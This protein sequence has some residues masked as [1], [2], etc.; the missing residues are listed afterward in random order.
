MSV[1]KFGR[2]GK[3]HPV[4]LR[5]EGAFGGGAG[6]QRAWI[7]WL[8]ERSRR[9]PRRVGVGSLT[10]VL[11]GQKT[12]VFR[13]QSRPE[14]EE[15]SLSV[16]YLDPEARSR[17]L[18]IVCQDASQLELCL[19][20][21][22]HLC[23]RGAGSGAGAAGSSTGSLLPPLLAV[24]EAD[25]SLLAAEEALNEDLAA[26]SGGSS[27]GGAAGGGGGGARSEGGGSSESS[28]RRPGRGRGEVAGAGAPAP[29][30]RSGGGSGLND[31]FVWGGTSGRW[32][33]G[34]GSSG[35]G[36]GAAALEPRLLRGSEALNVRSAGV[37]GEHG[38]LVTR[39]GRT[40]SW[41][42]GRGGRLGNGS[43]APTSGAGPA[44]VEVL[45]DRRAEQ[46]SCG[47]HHSV[48]LTQE[49]EVFTWGDD[50]AACG[51][52]GHGIPG[53][54][55]LS[56]RAVGAQSARATEGGRGGEEGLRPAEGDGPAANISWLPK[57]V[58]RWPA[59]AGPVCFVACGSWHTAAV[60]EAGS[61][62]TWGCGFRGRLGHGG[63]GRDEGR[64]RL[65]SV[66]SGKRVTHVA[67]GEWHTA[68]VVDTE[69]YSAGEGEQAVV[70]P[71]FTW[72]WGTR[73]SLGYAPDGSGESSG[74][75]MSP[76]AVPGIFFDTSQL[77]QVSCGEGHTAA[78]DVDGGAYVSGRLGGAWESEVFARVGGPLRWERVSQIASGNHHLAAL[79]A[80]GRC[81]TWG[82]GKDGQL[83]H[84]EAADR[85]EPQE[86]A[87]LAGRVVLQVS[88]GETSTAAVCEY[89]SLEAQTEFRE[90][91]EATKEMFAAASTAAMRRKA[92][93]AA[94]AAGGGSGG[95][96]GDASDGE[97]V[98]LTELKIR[99]RRRPTKGLRWRLRQLLRLLGFRRSM[100]K[101]SKG[102]AKGGSSDGGGGRT[103]KGGRARF[104]S[105]VQA[106]GA[107]RALAGTPGPAGS[108]GASIPLSAPPSATTRDSTGGDPGE[109]G[110][111]AAPG[112]ANPTAD[113]T[114]L[115][116]RIAE[117]EQQLAAERAAATD[118]PERGPSPT[119]ASA[120][121]A[122]AE[123]AVGPG[124][125]DQGPRIR[126]GGDPS[127]SA[128]DGGELLSL[129]A[130]ELR[131]PAGDGGG[132]NWLPFRWGGG[133]GEA[134]QAEVAG[135]LEAN[136]VLK[137]E[138]ALLRGQ[139]KE[140]ISGGAAPGAGAGTHQAPGLEPLPPGAP[141]AWRDAQTPI[142]S[143]RGPPTLALEPEREHP[144]KVFVDA[145]DVA[146]VDYSTI[147]QQRGHGAAHGLGGD[148]GG[149]GRRLFQEANPGEAGTPGPLPADPSGSPTARRVSIGGASPPPGTAWVEEVDAG[150]FLSLVK[151]ASGGNT[152]KGVRFSREIFS[153][154]DAE[155]YW[156]AQK[157]AIALKYNLAPTGGARGGARHRRT[158]SSA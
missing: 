105:G 126:A 17:S 22:R 52:L 23:R 73:G 99:G 123:G 48:V 76:R 55:L 69:A 103:G 128:G 118:S 116:E 141:S 51:L 97:H 61:L 54:P 135:L 117:L 71:L 104:Q 131:V 39:G 15:L 50:Q 143:A 115:A 111:V 145:Q 109:R 122:G 144:G 57:R 34:P 9:K 40:F 133:R 125:A 72:G 127:S 21:L 56:G 1:L 101:K 157:V 11:E 16:L 45:D 35:A 124:E 47:S 66:L 53:V 121:G 110:E 59:G 43:A 7:V 146:S 4:H 83:G 87:R 25:E 90:K 19:T 114:Q 32:A 84:R 119:G 94:G 10:D 58:E 81:Y 2:R 77:R 156:D 86:V 8:G 31:L 24:P 42:E 3:P 62:F 12:R 70:S 13:R 49:G 142:P 74:A 85:A 68:A 38:V 27:G 6:P 20:G 18:D 158:K 130:R 153:Q 98:H 95:G 14:L 78:L 80:S 65:V 64:P 140:A 5:L 108:D 75:Q 44:R 154:K 139:L 93:A 129:P 102:P 148:G 138:V 137:K 100:R 150:V 88:C 82:A 91:I 113:M 92:G 89:R 28:P 46:L 132:G 147:L 151:A 120:G 67:C 107:A 60:T 41:G 96:G 30:D 136:R 33:G 149:G 26:T 36:R 152:L 79:T 29:V 134:P 106:V 37:S 63:A 155:A 112:P